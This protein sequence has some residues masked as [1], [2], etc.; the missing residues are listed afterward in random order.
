M[1]SRL[2]CQRKYLF[3]GLHVSTVTLLAIQANNASYLD[4]GLRNS[5]SSK[6]NSRTWEMSE[7]ANSGLAIHS[8]GE[9]SKR[10]ANKN[11]CGPCRVE[12]KNGKICASIKTLAENSSFLHWDVDCIALSHK[13]ATYER[14]S[15]RM[16]RSDREIIHGSSLSWRVWQKNNRH[17]LTIV[18]TLDLSASSRLVHVDYKGCLFGT[19]VH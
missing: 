11:P 16:T 7:Q 1:S 3:E 9:E 18:K 4:N 19:S 2:N 6:F 10:L 5:T 8:V 13:D 12:S 14:I 15:S 17:T